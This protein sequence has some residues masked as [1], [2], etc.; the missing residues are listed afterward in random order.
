MSSAVAP[1]MA[2][3]TE[4]SPRRLLIRRLA[5]CF[6]RMLAS[7]NAWR[8]VGRPARRLLRVRVLPRRRGDGRLP[9]LMQVGRG[10]H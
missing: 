3:R 10:G 7:W 9:G 1:S 2:A 4:V 8:N 5:R 6:A